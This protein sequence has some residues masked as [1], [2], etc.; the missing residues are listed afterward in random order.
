MYVEAEKD[1]AS[2]QAADYKER[3]AKL[4]VEV[5]FYLDQKGEKVSDSKSTNVQ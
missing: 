4:Q 2:R 1:E 5:K 3:L